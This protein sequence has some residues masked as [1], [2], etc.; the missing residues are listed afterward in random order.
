M[1]KKSWERNFMFGQA[2]IT[3]D[4]FKFRKMSFNIKSTTGFYKIRIWFYL[5]E[6]DKVSWA[7]DLLF[8]RDYE[9]LFLFFWFFLTFWVIT[10]KAEIL[11]LTMQPSA[12]AFKIFYCYFG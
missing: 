2:K 6:K 12:F 3:M 9:R 1:E 11:C 5:C 4:L 10:W 8:I 7:I